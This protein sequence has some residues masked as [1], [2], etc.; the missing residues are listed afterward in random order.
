MNKKNYQKINLKT[1]KNNDHYLL[2]LHCKFLIISSAMEIPRNHVFYESL[3]WKFAIMSPWRF[4][5]ICISSSTKLSDFLL[6]DSPQTMTKSKYPFSQPALSILILKKKSLNSLTFDHLVFF[7]LSDFN[8]D[9]P[10]ITTISERIQNSYLSILTTTIFHFNFFFNSLTLRIIL[11]KNYIF[12][13]Q[14]QK[15]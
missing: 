5:I 11:L 8:Q 3:L 6:L 2:C 12:L 10:Q 15:K 4:S 13:S 1:E 14:C 7:K 9:S